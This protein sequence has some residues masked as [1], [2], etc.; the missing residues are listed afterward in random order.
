MRVLFSHNHAFMFV[1]G[2]AQILIEQTRLALLQLG[3]E[4]E[5]LRW[6]DRDQKGDLIHQFGRPSGSFMKE[7]QQS[8]CRVVVTDLL[9][10]TGARPRWQLGAYKLVGRLARRVGV[11]PRLDPF[12]VAFSRGPMPW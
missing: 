10:A 8:G 9:S 3:V 4:V 12:G 5:W 2:G 7:A 6:W 11:M 1:P